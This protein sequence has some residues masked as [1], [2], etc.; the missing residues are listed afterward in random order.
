VTDP[1]GFHLRTAAVV[2]QTAARFQSAIVF[3]HGE[4]RANGKS[5]LDLLLL[6]A[7]LGAELVLEVSG[8]DA[9]TAMDAL[10]GLLT[11]SSWADPLNLPADSKGA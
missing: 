4:R 9:D 1:E 10:V 5:P 8:T 3:T 11:D 6:A 7:G 2:A